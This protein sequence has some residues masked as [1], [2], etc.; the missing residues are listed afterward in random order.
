[1]NTQAKADTLP[2]SG[3]VTF[4]YYKDLAEAARFYGE[5]LGLEKTFDKGWVNFFKLT[6][7]S[8]VGLVDETHGFHKATDDNNVMVSIETPS[9]EAW[10][11]RAK[12]RGATFKTHPDFAGAGENMVTGFMLRDPGGYTVEFFRFNRRD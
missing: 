9:V 5:L 7:T 4:L 12:A 2:I 10:Y 6:E 8:S 1:M 11:E 3:Q